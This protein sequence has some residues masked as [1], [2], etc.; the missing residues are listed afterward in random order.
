MTKTLLPAFPRV[1]MMMLVPKKHVVV[2]RVAT[3][4]QKNA[5][6]MSLAL[7]NL[8][9]A[10]V[11]E[12]ARRS[13]V[14]VGPPEESATP[15]FAAVAGPL[16]HQIVLG[17]AAGSKRHRD[18]LSGGPHSSVRDACLSAHFILLRYARWNARE[19]VLQVDALFVPGRSYC[20]LSC[21]RVFVCGVC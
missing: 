20:K 17:S 10:I 14:H 7:A 5:R 12:P 8:L 16:Y 1:I 3:S 6:A 9:D 19:H 15:I 18:F 4:V 11:V 13:N 21:R 2:L